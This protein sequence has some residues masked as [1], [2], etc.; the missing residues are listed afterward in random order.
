[1]R[2]DAAFRTTPEAV[3]AT[4][5]NTPGGGTV[6]LSQIAR[7]NT[8]E[9]P[10]VINHEGG[11]RYIVVQSNVRGRDLGGFV[12]DVRRAVARDVSLPTG[13]YAAYGGQFE[14]QARATKRLALIVPLVLLLIAGLLYAGFGTIRH[15][16]IV[17]TAVPLA[18]VGG[19]VS[20]W[21]RGI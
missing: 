4:L 17:I 11:L 6:A 13:Y 7:V 21:A 16:L 3:A 19:I 18:L 14:N 15:T 8:V 5:V 20:L 9:G 10:E 1:M 12:A 2:L